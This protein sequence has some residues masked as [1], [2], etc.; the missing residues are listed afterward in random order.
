MQRA[1][2]A[3]KCIF[4]QLK[5]YFRENTYE[6]TVTRLTSVEGCKFFPNT[7]DFGSRTTWTNLELHSFHNK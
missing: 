5:N 1:W 3:L 2:G 4:F 6:E 7:R